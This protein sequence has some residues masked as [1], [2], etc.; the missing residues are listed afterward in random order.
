MDDTLLSYY[1][2]E[3][4]FIREMGAQFAAKYPKIAGRLQLEPDNC[5][6]P[7]TERLIEAFAYISGR[8][9]KKIDD[10]F[11]EIT[12]SIMGITYPHYN[13][14]IP[15]MTIVRFMPNEKSITEKGYGIPKDVT[16][17]SRPVKGVPCTFTLCSPV[18]L[19]PVKI[20]AVSL[21]DPGPEA[22]RAVQCLHIGLETVN[23]IDFCDLECDSLRFFLNGQAQHVFHLYQRLF[24]NSCGIELAYTD[25]KGAKQRIQLDAGAISPVGFD[26]EDKMLPFSKRSFPG[27]L[28]LFEY[29]TFPEKFLYFDLAGLETLRGGGKGTAI[30]LNIYLDEAVKREVVVNTETFALYTAPA[31]NLFKKIAEPM[32]VEHR[33]TEYR[34]VPDLR[35]A[36]ATE[37]Y[38][39]DRVTPATVSGDTE[40]EYRPFYSIRHHLSFEETGTKHVFWHSQRRPSGKKEDKGTEVY[41]SFTDLNMTPADPDTEI[42]TI[43]QTCTN[44]DLPSRLP[45]GDKRGDFTMELAA[46]ADKIICLVKPTP[47][48]RPFMGRSLQWRM[49]SHL[50]LNYISIVEGGEDALKEILNLYDF[51]GSAT[52]KQQV[53]GIVS[54]ACRHV[55]KRVRHA[56]ARGVE[57]TITMDGDKFVGSGLYL[58]GAVLE[59]FFAQ[60]VS[61]NSFSQLV[62][63]T[64]QKKEELKRWPPRSGNQILI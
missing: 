64:I 16:L 10:D 21:E 3:L 37:V 12:E 42:L 33:K 62:L 29:F 18:S 50:S 52:T 4:T 55:T 6:D 23:D 35:R 2:R 32:R 14:P 48:L 5:H 26:P 28:L 58:F 44:R 41:L 57:I 11:P 27:Y 40:K 9:H 31:V 39:V 1:E 15:S 47:T 8:I 61:V 24:N 51:Q 34:V 25:T 7:H 43:H 53:S 20:G 36:N 56:F 17:F 22:G 19:W 63:K 38:T 54:V 30:S 60:Y 45:F 59:R 13:N 46:P 49:I